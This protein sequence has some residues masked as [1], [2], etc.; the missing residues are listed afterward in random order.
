[1]ATAQQEIK[2][3]KKDIADLKDILASQVEDVTPNGNSVDNRFDMQAVK[4]R[5]RLAGVKARKFVQ[6]TQDQAKVA[7]DAA[8]KT[9]KARPFTTTAAAFASGALVAALLKRK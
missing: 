9:I 6:D 7:R 2:G 1:M 4:A 8:E 3:L 5:A